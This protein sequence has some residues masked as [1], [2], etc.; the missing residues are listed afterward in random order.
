MKKCRSISAVLA[1]TAVLTACSD[2]ENEPNGFEERNPL[3]ITAS[4]PRTRAVNSDWQLNDAIGLVLFDAGTTTP[5]DDKAN[6][7]YVT[8]DG[9]GTFNAKDEAN[10]VYLPTGGKTAD[11]LAYYPQTSA[12]TP[13]NLIVP[14]DVTAQINLPAIDLMVADKVTGLTAQNNTA[15]LSFRHKLCKLVL[16]VQKDDSSADVDISNATAVLKGTKAK[17]SWNLATAE[18]VQSGDVTDIALP[19][20]AD[21]TEATAIVLPTDAGSGVSITLT[22]KD[23]QSFIATLDPSLALAAGTVNT[24]TMTLHR[25]SAAITATITPWQTGVETGGTSTLD[26]VSGGNVVLPADAEGQFY[27]YTV[28]GY[29]TGFYN[30][31]K[32]TLTATT[33]IYWEQLSEA[34]HTFGATFVPSASVAAET[35]LE[36]DYLIATASNVS[37][38]GMVKFEMKHAMADFAIMLASKNAQGDVT[39][40]NLFTEAELKAAT[41]TFVSSMESQFDSNKGNLSFVA[42]MPLRTITLPLADASQ[43]KFGG[44]IAP[45]TITS[46]VITLGGKTYTFRKDLELKAGNT[47]ALTLNLVK[48]ATGMDVTLAGW[49]TTEL[50]NVNIGIDD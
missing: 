20:T 16:K 34:A 9:S 32:T 31:N 29:N 8:A 44:M 25:H 15:S 37:F 6:Y 40:S 2:K 49:S 28:D 47:N 33:P 48:S 4:I 21:G 5:C 1:I 7:C 26:V 19:M 38:G 50:G 3:T 35:N 39:T 22:T 46:V 18:L 42:S 45:Q 36:K 13:T 23:G 14:V 41:V 11:L 27:V 17:A 24:Y 43:I 30:W 10:K 12:V